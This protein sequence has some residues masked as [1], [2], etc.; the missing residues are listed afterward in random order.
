[1]CGM[2]SIDP[3]GLESLEER[4]NRRDRERFDNTMFFFWIVW[5]AVI[6][7]MLVYAALT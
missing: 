3:I 4:L 2:G 6:A 1:M 5:T 7:G